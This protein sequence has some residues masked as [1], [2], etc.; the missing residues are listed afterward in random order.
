MP[1]LARKSRVP[2]RTVRAPST[3]RLEARIPFDLKE[4]IETAAPLA[5]HTSVTDYLVQTLRKSASQTVE[6]SRRI[7]LEAEESIAFVRSLLA[8][9]EPNQALKAAFAVHREQV[10]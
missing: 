2:A 9:P 3:A 6:E 8:P 1:T 10:R 7:R 5:G 4:L